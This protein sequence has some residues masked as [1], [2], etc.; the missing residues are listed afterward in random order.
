[1]KRGDGEPTRGRA[2]GIAWL[3]T[4][5][6][7]AGCAMSGRTEFQERPPVAEQAPPAGAPIYA[8]SL[9]RVRFRLDGHTLAPDPD[10]T[11]AYI[12]MLR[13][14]GTFTEIAGPGAPENPAHARLALR[15]EMSRNALPYRIELTARM[16][17]D[18]LLPGTRD[19]RSYTSEARATRSYP[20]GGDY[21]AHLRVLMQEVSAVTLRDIIAQ[22]RGDP[23]LLAAPDFDAR[24]KAL[25]SDAPGD[26]P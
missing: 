23:V 17:L 6:L 5:A 1:M 2:P 9:P 15:A 16:S 25:G 7:V 8:A 20:V 18:V 3:I 11:R 26:V 10:V 13:R 21:D 14:A 4:G 12:R 19:V 22:L 24:R